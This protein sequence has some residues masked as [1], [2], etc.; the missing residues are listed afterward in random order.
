MHL[1]V[2]RRCLEPRLQEFDQT[3]QEA[4]VDM[5]TSKLSQ[6]HQQVAYAEEG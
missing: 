3:Y 4:N 5:V 6:S 2:V 1:L